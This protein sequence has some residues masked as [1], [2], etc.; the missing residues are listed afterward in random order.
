MWVCH[1]DAS[2]R[3]CGDQ[4]GQNHMHRWNCSR[5]PIGIPFRY[6]IE[7]LWYG[8]IKER[9]L[10]A[11]LISSQVLL[12][13]YIGWAT[14]VS[15]PGSR[16]SAFKTNLLYLVRYVLNSKHPDTSAWSCYMLQMPIGC[17]IQT[18]CDVGS[19]VT[20]APESQIRKLLSRS[21]VT[22]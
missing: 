13:T 3:P 11:A 15:Q 21:N 20:E 9:R 5:C 10:I 6:R 2:Q 22:G 18:V 8:M 16:S 4:I 17:N 19:R 7:M 12:Y 14:R 1:S